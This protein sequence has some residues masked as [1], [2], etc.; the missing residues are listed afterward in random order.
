MSV[1][2]FFFMLLTPGGEWIWRRR[3]VMTEGQNGLFMP[4]SWIDRRKNEKC[5]ILMDKEWG[6]LSGKKKSKFCFDYSLDKKKQTKSN[7]PVTGLSSVR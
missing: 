5:E 2:L 6:L 7:R 4:L 1:F 3:R